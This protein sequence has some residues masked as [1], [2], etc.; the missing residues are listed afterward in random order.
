[1]RWQLTGDWAAGNGAGQHIPV[2]E[3]I[4]GITDKYD[5]LTGIRWHGQDFGPALPQEAMA[6]DQ[7]AADE[8]S[9]QHPDHLHLLR[10][11]P[12]AVIRPYDFTHPLRAYERAEMNK[13]ANARLEEIYREREYAASLN[14]RGL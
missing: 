6:L 9:R 5:R 14:R 7:A 11:L 10:A 2:G 4:E 12:P 13:A 8:L 3:I 1:M